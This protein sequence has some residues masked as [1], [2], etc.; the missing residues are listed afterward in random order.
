LSSASLPA[1]G[2]FVGAAWCKV[3]G[4]FYFTISPE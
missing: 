1:L 2:S 3:K 4:R